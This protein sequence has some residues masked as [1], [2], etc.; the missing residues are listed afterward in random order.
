MRQILQHQ[1][2]VIY[3]LLYFMMILINFGELLGLLKRI[4]QQILLLLMFMILLEHQPLIPQQEVLAV[5]LGLFLV[6]PNI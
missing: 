1:I 3:T 5:G 6:V 4:I 2:Q